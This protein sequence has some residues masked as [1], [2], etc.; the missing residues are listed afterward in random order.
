MIYITLLLL[1][2]DLF[3]NICSNHY[4]NTPLKVNKLNQMGDCPHCPS[5]QISCDSGSYQDTPDSFWYFKRDL[6]KQIEGE[7]SL[8]ALHDMT[9]SSPCWAAVVLIRRYTV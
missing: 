5:I 9:L 6:N 4:F 1:E 7:S 8:I 2:N 3:N